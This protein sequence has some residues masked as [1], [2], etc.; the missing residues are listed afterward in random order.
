MP[1]K[2]PVKIYIETNNKLPY[3]DYESVLTK[4]AFI[5]DIEFTKIEINNAINEIIGNDKIYILTGVELDI[6]AEKKK[7]SEEIDY[8]T[9]F[10]QSVEIKLSNERFVQNAKPEILAKERQKL[11]DGQV[12]LQ[13]LKETLE[14]LEG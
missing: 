13:N 7:V 14:K 6:E 12:K 3:L 10:I 2:H 1:Q 8:Y 9:G 4:M 5:E 11:I